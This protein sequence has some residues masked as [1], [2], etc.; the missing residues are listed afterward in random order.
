MTKTAKQ[1]DAEIA[2]SL[3]YWKSHWGKSHVPGA[4]PKRLRHGGYTA[5]FQGIDNPHTAHAS[6]KWEI[7]RGRQ[8][9]ATMHEGASYGWGRP[10]I[11]TTQLVWA[12]GG[13]PP[14]TSDPKSPY[15]GWAFD[16]GPFDSYKEAMERLAKHADRLI[17]WRK[18]HDKIVAQGVR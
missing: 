8:V 6:A 15:Y 3:S 5:T 16:L 4:F 14:G 7:K 12:A 13:L 11:S 2:E 1:L 9:V 17:N 10:T 18:K